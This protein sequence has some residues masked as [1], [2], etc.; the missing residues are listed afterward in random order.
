MTAN[1][2]TRF[3]SYLEPHITYFVFLVALTGML[4]SLYFSEISGYAPCIFCWYQR[5]ALYPIVF[6]AA[7]AI[8]ARDKF[9]YRYAFPMSFTGM[10]LAVYHNLLYYHV[11]PERLRPCSI[12]VPCDAVYIKWLGF[13]TIPLMSLV[14]FTLIT[15]LLV[16]QRWY[17]KHPAQS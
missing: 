9:M 16:I 8:Y 10:F 17:A 2:I 14:A 6:I 13:I 4:G 11:I 1:M 5:I 15:T 3:R 12:G 7:V